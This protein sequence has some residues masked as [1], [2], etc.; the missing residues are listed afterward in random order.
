MPIFKKFLLS[1][2]LCTNILLFSVP[3]RQIPAKAFGSIAFVILSEY[4]ATAN[5]GDEFYIAAITSD[6]K[7]PSWKSSRSSIA[8]V[9]T[10]GKVTAKKAGSAVIT[11]KIKG[12]EASC[13]VTVQKT[14]I[15][16]SC[17]S[18]SIERGETL[19]LNAKSSGSSDITWKSNR[20]TI[21]EV[22]DNGTV[23]GIKPG[24]ATITA[25]ADTVKAVCRITV[26]R[27]DVN[28]SRN[29]ITLYRTQSTRLYAFV[30]SGAMP[31]WKTN[32]KSVAV[33]DH[34][35]TVIAVKHG[36]AI[37][38]ATVDGVSKTCEVVVK[39]PVMT[40]KPEE[41]SLKK[42]EKATLNAYVSSY[43]LPVWST[44]NPNIAKV[45]SR[46]KVTAVKKGRAYIYACEDGI[47][48]R[49]TVY[50]TE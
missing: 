49:C 35:G 30:S 6:G 9:N 28:L 24:E 38:T 27:P 40:L 22:D 17:E 11:A 26:K 14:V 36:T 15:S 2:F 3:V 45:D 5:I 10:Y 37:I 29:K 25:S 21:A 47:K 34:T 12:A 42:G 48:L 46:G 31:T 8:S 44:S 41:L 33:V 7:L 16:I 13:R 39:Q 23:T 50:V 19:K 18:A 20:P 43:N 4:K 1:I 32:K